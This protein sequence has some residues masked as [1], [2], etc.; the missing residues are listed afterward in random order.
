MVTNEGSDGI[1][2]DPHKPILTVIHFFPWVVSN[3]TTVYDKKWLRIYHHK[4]HWQPNSIWIPGFQY[5]HL[6]FQ[7]LTV[8]IRTMDFYCQMLP[9]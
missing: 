1:L 4:R 7:S 8:L 6:T 9:F 5:K 2:S 3:D